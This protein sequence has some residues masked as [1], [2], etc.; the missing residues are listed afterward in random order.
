MLSLDHISMQ[1]GGRYLFDDLSFMIGPHDRI[2]LVGSNGAGK[3]TLLKIIANL[4]QAESGTVSK[5]HYI[6]AGYLP[7]D[8]VTAA[9]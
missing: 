8:G 5:A 6:T 7:Q 9:G 1:F 2:G 3:S 4:A